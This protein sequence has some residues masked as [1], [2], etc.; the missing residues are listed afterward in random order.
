MSRTPQTERIGEAFDDVL[1]AA[2]EG[3]D[4]AV[5]VLFRSLQPR[6]LRFLR[7]GLGADGEDVASQA[8]LEVARKLPRFDGN[9]DDFAALLFTVARRR[10]ADHRRAVRRRPV[11]AAADDV[12]AAIPDDSAPEDDV[13]ARL[14]GED[15]ARQIAA[16]L[17]PDQA[18]IVLLRVI[19][20]FSAEEVAAIVGRRAG[21]V[22]V[23]QHRAL[24]RL[25]ERL[26]DDL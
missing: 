6:L 26:G 9:E 25:A 22:R 20:G 10:M 16:I 15:A 3:A 7:A 19:G 24:R 23:L 14:R 4:W 5:A 17:P 12:L 18:E 13:I 21:T 8:W 2:R 1:A 11:A